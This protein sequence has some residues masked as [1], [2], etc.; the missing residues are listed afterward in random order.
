V[1]RYVVVVSHCHPNGRP[2][3]WGLQD[4]K[5]GFRPFG[6]QEFRK[7]TAAWDEAQRLN[8][9]YAEMSE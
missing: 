3:R 2:R 1:I 5:T 4:E 9:I 7:A 6:L 8:Q